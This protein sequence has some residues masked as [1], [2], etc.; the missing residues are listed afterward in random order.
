LKDEPITYKKWDDHKIRVFAG[1]Q[2]A[3][4]VLMRMYTL[5]LMAA[6]K[7]YPLVFESA[8]GCNAAGKDWNEFAKFFTWEDRMVNGDFKAFD[9]RLPPEVMMAVFEYYVYILE[10][11]GFDEEDIAVVRG[12]ATEIC[13]PCYEMLGTII[14]VSGSNPSGHSLTVEVNNDGNRLVLRYV[15]YSLHD[16]E[17]GIP[18]FSDVVHLLCYGDD[19]IMSVSPSEQKLNHTVI[20]EELAKIGMVYT[21]ADKESESV[22]FINLEE[23]DFLKRKFKH[24]PDIGAIVGPLAESSVYK[25]LHF[26]RAKTPLSKPAYL[27][28]V[29]SGAAQE[30]FLHGKEKFEKFVAEAEQIAQEVDEVKDYGFKVCDILEIPTYE[31]LLKRYEETNSV[32]LLF[33]EAGTV[34]VLRHALFESRYLNRS[35]DL[36]LLARRSAVMNSCMGAVFLRNLRLAEIEHKRADLMKALNILFWDVTEACVITEEDFINPP[37][38]GLYK[39][40]FELA[41]E[42]RMDPDDLEV[43]LDHEYYKLVLA[44]GAFPDVYYA[45]EFFTDM[46]Q[47]FRGDLRARHVLMWHATPIRHLFPREVAE[48]IWAYAQPSLISVAG[49]Y[50]ALD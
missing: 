45:P 40:H 33:P 34:P 11:A 2:V 30:M 24:D 22:P 46:A 20:A 28:D 43:A 23:C 31:Q 10:I 36:L 21:M 5:P 50:F 13:Y 49:W 38:A 29:L 9:K 1:S 47:G 27:A 14:K 32:M 18:S 39:D 6:R 48:L 16:D 37:R 3:F 8:V 4:T 17:E 41:H 42:T 35:S 19:N 12:I 25:R 7:K 26:F 15:Y 44:D